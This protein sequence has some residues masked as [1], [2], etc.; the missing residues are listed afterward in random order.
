MTRLQMHAD[1][2]LAKIV[3]SAKN[4]GCL[5]RAMGRDSQETDIAHALL[6]LRQY[7]QHVILCLA[8]SEISLEPRAFVRGSKSVRIGKPR[9]AWC[10]TNK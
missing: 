4:I 5:L 8:L 10:L 9:A 7:R 2:F 1:F 3:Q 6:C